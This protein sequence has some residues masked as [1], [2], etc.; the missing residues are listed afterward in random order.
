[1]GYVLIG[2]YH[3]KICETVSKNS[4]KTFGEILAKMWSRLASVVVLHFIEHILRIFDANYDHEI[5]SFI[6][7]QRTTPKKGP[8]RRV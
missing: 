5:V 4:A 2:K 3:N 8:T 6:V 1:M 7:S